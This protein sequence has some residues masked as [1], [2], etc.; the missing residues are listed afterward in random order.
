M[1]FVAELS[2]TAQWICMILL[3]VI[4]LIVL[5]DECRL[6][7]K[8]KKAYLYRLW[9]WIEWTFLSCS[10]ASIAFYFI[11]YRYMQTVGEIFTRTNGYSF[12]DFSLLTSSSRLFNIFISLSGFFSMI[13]FSHFCQ[14]H[15]RLS[16]FTRTLS[17][18]ACGLISFSLM[19]SVVFVAFICLFYF[20]FV[21]KVSTCAT[22]LETSRMLFEMSLLKFDAA[23][24]SDAASCLGPITFTMFIL[25]I[26]FVCLSMFLSIINESFRVSRNSI[27]EDDD[28]GHRM[29]QQMFR[30]IGE[31]FMRCIGKYFFLADSIMKRW[32][33]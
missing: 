13:R 28:P 9:S 19:F 2:S 1:F 33:F 17:K 10:M 3:V 8:M 25:V 6:M 12:I 26:V 14:Y 11:Q 5:V 18:A 4:I 21:S 20:L 15:R 32:C 29:T 7:M 16:L 30:L 31:K 22:L 23:E 24:L 27:D